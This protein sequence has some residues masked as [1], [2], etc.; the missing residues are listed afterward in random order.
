M[1]DADAREFTVRGVL[2]RVSTPSWSKAWWEDHP[3][4]SLGVIDC[5][6]FVHLIDMFIFLNKDLIHPSKPKNFR[7]EMT[8]FALE[9]PGLGN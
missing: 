4:T 1:D 2:T 6:L 5:L 8:N 7:S 3:L 9:L